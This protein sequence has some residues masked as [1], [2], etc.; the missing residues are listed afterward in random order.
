MRNPQYFAPFVQQILFP[1]R[2]KSSVPSSRSSHT[3]FFL[4]WSTSWDR[5]C[6]HRQFLW[7][8]GF[9]CWVLLLGADPLVQVGAPGQT[10]GVQGVPQ[11]GAR[12][13]EAAWENLCQFLTVRNSS[14]AL[15]DRVRLLFAL[16]LLE[17]SFPH[18]PTHELS[19]FQ[20]SSVSHC[21]L[22]LSPALL[23]SAFPASSVANTTSAGSTGHVYVHLPSK[24]NPGA[25][26][27]IS[28]SPS[29]A[30][31]ALLSHG[32]SRG[33]IGSVLLGVFE[34]ARNSVV[35]HQGGWDS[36]MGDE[37]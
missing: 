34:D 35:G 32:C 15:T 23:L 18:A 17:F 22:A 2:E 4:S 7:R 16:M 3:L 28:C 5:Q 8:L 11:G 33:G 20:E 21:C 19:P 26:C 1:Q 30:G 14:W 36:R 6:W 24:G 27:C 9:H 10:G 37:R 12:G 13:A 29:S 31:P 25:T